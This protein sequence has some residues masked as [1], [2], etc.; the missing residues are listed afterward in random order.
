MKAKFIFT[1]V[2][3]FCITNYILPQ[4]N[5]NNIIRKKYTGLFNNAA[6]AYLLNI[7]RPFIEIETDIPEMNRY[8]ISIYPIAGDGYYDLPVYGKYSVTNNLS[9]IGSVDLF[10]TSY[11][12]AGKKFTGFGDIYAGA[13]YRFQN[14]D[15]FSHFIQSAVKFPTASFKG[16]IG[17]GKFDFHFGAGQSFAY[18]NF[19]N[20][21]TAGISLL[22]PA[23]FPSS[24]S[25]KLPTGVLRILDSLTSGYDS[26]IEP[27][28]NLSVSPTYYFNDNFCIE[29]GAAFSRNMKLNYNTFNVYGDLAYTFGKYELF[30]GLSYSDYRQINYNESEIYAGAAYYL[31]DKI[32][33]RLQSS[34][35]IHNNTASYLS[36]EIDLGN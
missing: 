11:N 18:N 23:D 26:S 6:E 13:T 9:L 8:S 35:G 17:S 34:F 5:S 31:T 4:N 29:G 3:L 10:T 33:F 15:M 7:N 14:S 19:L 20:D 22:K 12:I 25:V 27:Q 16:Q 2:V 1:A 32:S 28:L 24:G 30:S 21:F 36:G